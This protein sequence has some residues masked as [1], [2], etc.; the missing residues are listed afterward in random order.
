MKYRIVIIFILGCY[1]GSFSQ[2]LD[3]TLLSRYGIDS[4]DQVENFPPLNSYYWAW[5]DGKCGVLFESN[6][7]LP[8][9]YDTKDLKFGDAEMIQ[10]LTPNEPYII[11]N[12]KD[13]TVYQIDLGDREITNNDSIWTTYQV[14]NMIDGRSYINITQ[15][16]VTGDIASDFFP[17][18]DL[19]LPD[20]EFIIDRINDTLVRG[21]YEV[22]SKYLALGDIVLEFKAI[23][24]KK[25]KYRV[26]IHAKYSRKELTTYI[27]SA[28]DENELI[29]IKELDHS[30][31]ESRIIRELGY[32]R[33]NDKYV[34][35]GFLDFQ[36][37]IFYK[38]LKRFNLK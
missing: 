17:T 33:K 14:V 20:R 29:T 18:I 28:N 7:V 12:P 6:L 19:H 26:K 1:F 22:D 4:T 36:K 27:W 34:K 13:S 8:I 37:M 9:K 2:E 38:K 25:L 30:I 32:Y 16:Y 11:F 24:K 23:N 5:S 21:F 3:S 10:I 31:T 15:Q 35:I